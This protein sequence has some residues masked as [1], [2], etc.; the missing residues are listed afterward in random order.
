MHAENRVGP[1]LGYVYQLAAGAG[2]TS[3]PF[4]P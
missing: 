1:A 2:W 3:L 4:L